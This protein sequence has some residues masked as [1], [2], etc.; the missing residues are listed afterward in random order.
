MKYINVEWHNLIKIEMYGCR[1]NAGPS[2]KT[3]FL[4]IAF[5]HFLFENVRIRGEKVPID[6]ILHGFY[7]T[8]K[9][10]SKTIF[11]TLDIYRDIHFYFYAF[12]FCIICCV[13]SIFNIIFTWIFLTRIRYTWL[14]LNHYFIN[15]FNISDII[16]Q[17]KCNNF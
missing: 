7:A 17:I 11:I 3:D 5:T 4:Q 14:L 15:G 12:D 6:S 2:I 8:R 13:Y 10:C 9:E 1:K 16:L